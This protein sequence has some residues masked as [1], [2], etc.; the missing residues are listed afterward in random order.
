ME[1]ASL[2]MDLQLVRRLRGRTGFVLGTRP[3]LNFVVAE[4]SPPATVKLGEEH[5]HL[6]AYPPGGSG[7]DPRAVSGA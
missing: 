4:L 6:G 3:A 1:T 5:L 7:V 2:W